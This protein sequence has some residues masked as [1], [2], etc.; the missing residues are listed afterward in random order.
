[1]S[2]QYDEERS[3]I[4]RCICSMFSWEMTKEGF[5]YWRNIEDA[6]WIT[7]S[8]ELRK[9]GHTEAAPVRFSQLNK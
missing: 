5:A 7:M 3:V 4:N 1:M 2:T 6:T 9:Y 8:K